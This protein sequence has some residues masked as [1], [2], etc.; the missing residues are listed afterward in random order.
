[1]FSYSWMKS[2][3]YHVRCTIFKIILIVW[4]T[5]YFIHYLESIVKLYKWL[6]LNIVDGDWTMFSAWSDCSVTC[7]IGTQVRTRIC[8]NPRS[9]NGGKPCV[10]ENSEIR[11]CDTSI[12][13]KGKLI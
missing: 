8:E 11:Q 4:S 2:H 7:G 9:Q 1:M 13:C 5:G 12:K 6:Y 10:G 3:I